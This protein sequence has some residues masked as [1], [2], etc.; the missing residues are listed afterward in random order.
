MPVETGRVMA[1]GSEGNML[2]APVG[3][4]GPPAVCVAGLPG[5]G[6]QDM[7]GKKANAAE[8]GG[9][10]PGIL[11]LDKADQ[12]EAAMKNTKEEGGLKKL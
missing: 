11:P 4:C 1:V 9:V 5:L 12:W 7:E 10:A 8:V 2:V 6:V 3:F